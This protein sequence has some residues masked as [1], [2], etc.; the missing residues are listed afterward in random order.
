MTEKIDV[1]VLIKNLDEM[2]TKLK[3]MR[4]REELIADLTTMSEAF[5]AA[6]KQQGSENV[7]VHHV[8][9]MLLGLAWQMEQRITMIE[10]TLEGMGRELKSLISPRP[11]GS[12]DV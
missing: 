7:E 9:V 5:E 12:Y 2:F 1:P 3:K 11:P 10:L 6:I 8:M 4:T